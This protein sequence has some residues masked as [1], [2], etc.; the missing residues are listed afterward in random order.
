MKRSDNQID[1]PGNFKHSVLSS[2]KLGQP[3][4]TRLYRNASLLY[5]ASHDAMGSGS[6]EPADIGGGSF[7]SG[8]NFTNFADRSRR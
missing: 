4:T 2:Y 6:F 1:F 7:N 3:P 5:M 8:N